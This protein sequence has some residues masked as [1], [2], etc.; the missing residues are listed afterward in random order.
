MQIHNIHKGRDFFN[1]NS[2]LVWFHVE[3][4]EY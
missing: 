1:V 2:D 3:K 4:S